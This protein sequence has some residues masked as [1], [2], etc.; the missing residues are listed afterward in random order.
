M[1]PSTFGTHPEG[2]FTLVDGAAA[3]AGSAVIGAPV[4]GQLVELP[5]DVLVVAVV[6]EVVDDE[7]AVVPV[8]DTLVV[9][10]PPAA[11][12]VVPVDCE[13]ATAIAVRGRATAKRAKEGRMTLPYPDGVR[14]S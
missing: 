5:V 2:T 3:Q 1:V 4:P 7:L 8:A 13:Q 10:D 11:V 14:E 12:V 6:A 9:V